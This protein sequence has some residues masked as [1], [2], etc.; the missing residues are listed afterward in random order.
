M[1][2]TD[3]HVPTFW[4]P[5]YSRYFGMAC[6]CMPFRLPI[7]EDKPQRPGTPSFRTLA[8]KSIPMIRFLEQKS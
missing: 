8:P 1:A 3:G 6:F 7:N 5:V 2:V 4:A